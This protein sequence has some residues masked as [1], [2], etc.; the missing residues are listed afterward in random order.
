MKMNP[1]Y[2]PLEFS[3]W[4]RHK[5]VKLA[6]SCAATDYL[7]EATDT[8]N[9]AFGGNYSY[10]NRLETNTLAILLAISSLQIQIDAITKK[11]SD[12]E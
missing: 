4:N 2:E 3:N 6:R 10:E 11:G 5:H 7:G 9:Q 8:L 12:D 1:D